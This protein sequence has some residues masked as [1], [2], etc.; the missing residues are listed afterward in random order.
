MLRENATEWVPG[1]DW[2]VPPLTPLG[3]QSQ[4]VDKAVYFQMVRPHNGTAA[5]KRLR[6]KAN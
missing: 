3:L 4:F 1:D 6:E 5:L 2:A